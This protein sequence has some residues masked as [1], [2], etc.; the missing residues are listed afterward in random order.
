MVNCYARWK[1]P[2]QLLN[3]IIILVMMFCPAS[4][5]AAELPKHAP[6]PGGIALIKLKTGLKPVKVTYRNKRVLTIKNKE[7]WYAIVGL[8]LATKPGR[9]HISLKNNHGESQVSFTVNGKEYATQHLTIKNKRKVN[10]TADDLQRIYK[11]KII[12]KKALR[13][14]SETDDVSLNFNIPVEGRFSSPFGLRRFFNGQARKPHSGLDIAAAEGTPVK[15]PTKGTVITTGNYFFNGNTIFIDHGQGLVSMFCHL[16]KINVAAGETIDRGQVL[17]EI[18]MTGR[19]TGPHLHWGVS[20]NDARVEPRL[21][22]S[23]EYQ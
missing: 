7:A 14:F 3:R 16:S 12:I 23:P 5:I 21:F 20:L 2:S 9:H 19:V 18:G 6:V 17:G 4:L 8:P 15:S 11:E 1:M 13:T 10:P 22:L